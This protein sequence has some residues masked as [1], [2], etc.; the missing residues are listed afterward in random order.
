MD[1]T[2]WCLTRVGGQADRGTQK[3]LSAI[4]NKIQNS[5]LN[6]IGSTGNKASVDNQNR[7]SRQL[8]HET[9]SPMLIEKINKN[10]EK[11]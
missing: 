6:R 2:N 7:R 10:K 9:N 4:L 3:N 8:N 5:G 11:L 1:R